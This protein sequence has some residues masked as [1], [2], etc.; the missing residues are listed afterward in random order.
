MV[1]F[2]LLDSWQRTDF[3]S[4]EAGLKIVQLK[5]NSQYVEQND[6]WI[7]LAQKS[8]WAEIRQ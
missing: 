4:H 2:A 3:H 6:Y 7:R 8:R 1:A 5:L